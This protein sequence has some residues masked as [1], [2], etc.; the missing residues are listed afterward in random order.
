MRIRLYPFFETILLMVLTSEFRYN[1][2]K[3]FEIKFPGMNGWGNNSP[4]H[5]ES[6]WFTDGSRIEDRSGQG[7]I[8]GPE[9]PTYQLASVNMLQCSKQEIVAIM[10]CALNI[11][12]SN[13]RGKRITIYSDSHKT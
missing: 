4:V 8:E 9:G 3:N 12:S 13:L 2:D 1:F 5:A 11:L 6:T 7:S 10:E